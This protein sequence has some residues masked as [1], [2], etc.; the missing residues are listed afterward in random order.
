MTTSVTKSCVGA[1][2]ELARTNSTWHWTGD[3]RRC[4]A[5]SCFSASRLNVAGVSPQMPQPHCAL[6]I[7]R[8][9]DLSKRDSSWNENITGPLGFFRVVSWPPCLRLPLASSEQNT[10]WV[11]NCRPYAQRDQ[12]SWMNQEDW[13]DI[14]HLALPKM[15]PNV[16]FKEGQGCT[17]Y[18]D[19]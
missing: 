11:S 15:T 5:L 16:V 12:T 3:A 8:Q 13:H 18:S 17:T 2:P 9:R 1:H 19:W 4:I 14:E 7:S 6:P 10:S